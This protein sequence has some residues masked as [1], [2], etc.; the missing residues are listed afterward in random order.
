MVLTAKTANG[1]I[2]LNQ[3]FRLWMQA[4]STNTAMSGYEVS[5]DVLD[6]RC[7]PMIR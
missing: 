3:T 6:Y 1:R 7:L 5:I 2:S 4:S